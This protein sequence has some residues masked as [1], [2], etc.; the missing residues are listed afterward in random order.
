MCRKT[1]SKNKKDRTI[2]TTEHIDSCGP[3]NNP[4]VSGT[5]A[6]EC[7]AFERWF[8]QYCTEIADTT[9]KAIYG[10]ES[11]YWFCKECL[12]GKK[13]YVKPKCLGTIDKKLDV[14]MEMN[15]DHRTL[16]QC[17]ST[18][19]DSTAKAT[20]IAAQSIMKLND[21]FT[22]MMPSINKI[23]HG[24]VSKIS[25]VIGASEKMAS[26]YATAAATESTKL[27]TMFKTSKPRV[28]SSIRM[29]EN[30]DP[31]YQN[32]ADIKRSF[33]N[34]F[35]KKKLLYASR[36]T[37]AHIHFEFKSGEESKEIEMEWQL[38]FLGSET[39]CRRLRTSQNHSVLIEDV[40]KAEEFTNAK[41]NYTSGRKNS[42]E[43]KPKDSSKKIR[44]F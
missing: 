29:I 42:L 7:T 36:T 19:L 28:I 2:S 22:A 33:S 17:N 38:S 15:Q 27:G 6:I 14:L 34:C 8:H 5:R 35:S 9:T 10:I 4:V 43:R 44:V 13:K 32:S 24:V 30:A 12:S 40:P 25:S 41:V 26:T 39:I 37:T 16:L 20:T 21:D 18:K 31:S 1:P 11:I 3:C 23:A